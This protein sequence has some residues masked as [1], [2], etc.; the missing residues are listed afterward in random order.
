[1]SSGEEIGFESI[2]DGAANTICIGES[3]GEI[4]SGSRSATQAWT[5][6]GLARGRGKRPWLSASSSSQ[7]LI[8]D[9]KSSSMF[10]FGST[11]PNGAN[12]SYADG[13]VLFLRKSVEWKELYHLCGMSDGIDSLVGY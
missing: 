12:F 1:M 7:G 2:L 5:V 6:G 8:G 3:L 10:G 13:S 4:S 9:L 11:H